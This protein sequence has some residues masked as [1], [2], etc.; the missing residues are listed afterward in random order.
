MDHDLSRRHAHSHGA[1]SVTL[2]NGVTVNGVSL[3]TA[4]GP[5]PFI[6]SVNAGLPG[7]DATAGQ[8]VL[9]GRGQ[10]RQASAGS[11]QSLPARSCSAI[12]VSNARRGEEPG[13]QGRRRR[14]MILVNVTPK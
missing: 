2:G 8:P 1:G 13:S 10:W 12:A 11:G 3:A 5:A 4:V 14:R 6:D 7:A 9:Y